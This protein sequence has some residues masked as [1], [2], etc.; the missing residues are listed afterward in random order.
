VAQIQA[1]ADSLAISMT[2][3]GRY[4]RSCSL[5]IFLCRK[6]KGQV[7]PA[8][9]GPIPMTNPKLLIFATTIT[10]AAKQPASSAQFLLIAGEHVYRNYPNSIIQYE[11][12]ATL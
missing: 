12:K 9:S 6:P 3:G 10:S 5:A 1:S 8:W 4:I 2:I 11:A 7:S